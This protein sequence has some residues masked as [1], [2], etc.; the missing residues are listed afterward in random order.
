MAQQQFKSV[1]ALGFEGKVATLRRFLARYRLARS[2]RTLG[3]A[4][5]LAYHPDTAQGYV[6]LLSVALHWSALEQ[7]SKLAGLDLRDNQVERTLA[8]TSLGMAA[9]SRI[10]RLPTHKP[11][12]RGILNEVHDGLKAKL[13]SYM[14]GDDANILSVARGIRHIFL[15]GQ[16]TPN[17][18]K[19]EPLQV[20]CICL[21]LRHFLH[22]LM[23]QVFESK[24][25]EAGV[26]K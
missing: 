19:A 13:E 11:L 15:H 21:A 6:A 24:L 18:G 22:R 12:L 4:P 16:L 3:F 8:C 25:K 20:S 1:R 7:L 10:R 17:I 26:L 23:N 5:G 9:N 2:V 14:E